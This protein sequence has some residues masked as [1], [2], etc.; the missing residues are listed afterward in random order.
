M[1][2][3]ALTLTH[4][5]RGLAVLRALAVDRLYSSRGA[6]TAQSVLSNQ[7]SGR[8]PEMLPPAVKKETL[9]VSNPGLSRRF[10]PACTN[11]MIV[12]V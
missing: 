4:Q 3:A 5:L 9:P 10:G 11:M 12:Q 2:C 6:G 8:A 1:A 7:L